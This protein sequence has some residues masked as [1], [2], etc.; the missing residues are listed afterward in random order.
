MSIL[1]IV[2]VPGK[3]KI[4]WLHRNNQRIGV[5]VA[6]DPNGP[7]KRF[8]KP[9]LDITYNDDTAPDALMTSNPSVCQMKDGKIL[10]VYKAVG[11]NHRTKFIPFPID[12]V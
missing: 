11:K 6:N 7:W 8:D 2:S 3:Q 4:N 12:L 5:A 9:V 1:M 10:M